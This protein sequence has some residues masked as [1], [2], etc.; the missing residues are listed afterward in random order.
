MVLSES[1][2]GLF[3][4]WDDPQVERGH[5]GKRNER[6]K[7]FILVDDPMRA[8]GCLGF[9]LLSAKWQHKLWRCNSS[10][11]QQPPAISSATSSNFSC[12]LQQP[13]VQATATLASSYHQCNPERKQQP[14]ATSSNLQ[15]ELQQPPAI[16]SN[17]QCKLECNLHCHR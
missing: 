4:E 6:N 17:L 16:C 13:P 5:S 9:E 15:C 10:S 2:V 12:N 7:V 1:K 11:R 8:T 3:K 14:P